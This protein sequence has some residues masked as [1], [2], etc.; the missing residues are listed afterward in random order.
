MPLRG[1]QKIAGEVSTFLAGFSS[2]VTLNQELFSRI[3]SVYESRKGIQNAEQARLLEETYQDFVRNGASLPEAKR[4]DLRNIDQELAGLSPKFSENLLK[5]TN[6]YKLHLSNKEDLAGIPE[7]AI[8]QAAATASEDGKEG[9][10]FTLQ[11]PDFMP[12]MTYAEN[13]E[14]RKQ[15][16]LAFRSRGMGEA[17]TEYGQPAGNR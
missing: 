16:Y 2:D 1:I 5:A 14:L 13:R 11:F 8:E 15:M 7:M 4:E 9:W 12:F 6:H 3:K 10:V 17:A